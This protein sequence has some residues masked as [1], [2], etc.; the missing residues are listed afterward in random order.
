MQTRFPDAGHGSG[1]HAKN[2]LAA[3]FNQAS[4]EMALLCEALGGQRDTAF[5]LAGTGDLHVTVGAGRNSRLGRGL[6]QGHRVSE[7]LSGQLA[8]ETVEGADTARVLG[9]WLRGVGSLD[10][11]ALPLAH[12]IIDA[13][14]EDRPFG[15]D[16][17]QVGS[18]AA[19]A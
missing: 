6:G 5:D 10:A 12:A 8:G 11:H 7:M 13:V 4:R 14:L 16:F 1:T 19:A 15:F 3:A 2:P 9:P 18:L 17:R